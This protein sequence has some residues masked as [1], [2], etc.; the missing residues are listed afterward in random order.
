MLAIIGWENIFSIEGKMVLELF[1][2]ADWLETISIC[3]MSL[4]SLLTFARH[5]VPWTK[6]GGPAC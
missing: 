2:E 3:Q 1:P 5:M 6:V 4:S